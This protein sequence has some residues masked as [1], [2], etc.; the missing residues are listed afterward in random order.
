MNDLDNVLRS[1]VDTAT[2]RTVTPPFDGVERR[3]RMRQH[4]QVAAVAVAVTAVI[5][6]GALAVPRIEARQVRPADGGDR[7]LTAYDRFL[8][9][10]DAHVGPEPTEGT[11]ATAVGIPQDVVDECY[12]QSGYPPP[13]PTATG[14]PSVRGE[15]LSPVPS[16]PE[17]DK[18]LK[19]DA[20]VVEGRTGTMEWG[21]AVASSEDASWCFSMELLARETGVTYPEGEYAD[22]D[23]SAGADEPDDLV[24]W[25]VWTT[26]A[27]GTLQGIWGAVDA[28]A[29]RFE[30]TVEGKQHRLDL[31]A[32]DGVEQWKFLATMIPVEAADPDWTAVA[33]DEDGRVVGRYS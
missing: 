17:C 5:A 3:V 24:R 12:W 4:R 29:V 18:G 28:K 16:D 10:L 23:A 1:A 13:T 2:A 27:G 25:G 9:C 6:G 8:A 32:H 15:L 14:R 20:T 19:V 21:L 30:V 7:P 11:F 31:V 33:Y 26:E 22:N